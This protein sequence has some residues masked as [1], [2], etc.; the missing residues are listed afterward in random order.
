MYSQPVCILQQAHSPLPNGKQQ[1]PMLAAGRQS[2]E[3]EQQLKQNYRAKRNTER[4]YDAFL[5][6]ARKDVA[7]EAK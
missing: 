5:D 1:T 3:L 4:L 2:G 7:F 6:A